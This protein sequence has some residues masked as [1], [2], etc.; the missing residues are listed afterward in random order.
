[1]PARRRSPAIFMGYGQGGTPALPVDTL[2]V[3]A[4]ANPGYPKTVATASSSAGNAGDVSVS[5]ETK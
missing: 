3:Y 2:P 4:R 5:P 1:M